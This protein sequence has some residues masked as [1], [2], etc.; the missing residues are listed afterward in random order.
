MAL[1]YIPYKDI[2]LA[3]YDNCVNKAINGTIFGNS[4][5]LKAVTG[6]FDL[7]TDGDYEIVMP[8]PYL[9]LRLGGKA[10]VHHPLASR[11]GIYSSKKLSENKILEFVRAIPT[12]FKN[13][14]IFFNHG[15]PLNSDIEP[16]TRILHRIYKLGLKSDYNQIRGSFSSEITDTC[17]AEEKNQA[18]VQTE[19]DLDEAIKCFARFTRIKSWN[20]PLQRLLTEADKRS[21]LFPI[22]YRDMEGK[23]VSVGFFLNTEDSIIQIALASANA[24]P[25]PQIISLDKVIREFAGEKKVFDMNTIQSVL[26][27]NFSAKPNDFYSL[28]HLR[29]QDKW[30]YSL[31]LN[32]YRD[33]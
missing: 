12:E 24:E 23:V 17:E 30:L 33:K 20:G 29:K 7:I 21:I 1:K 5:Y 10:I 9:N 26:A 25:Y 3:A 4:W 14:Q 13:V 15:N 19:L 8:L 31:G 2:D 22:H 32:I 16:Y 6:K 28:T 27:E 18:L 11:L